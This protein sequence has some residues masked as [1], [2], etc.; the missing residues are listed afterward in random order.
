MAGQRTRRGVAGDRIPRAA[1]RKRAAH[2]LAFVARHAERVRHCISRRHARAG[3]DR[4][5]QPR[6]R[7]PLGGGRRQA[8]AGAGR[9]AGGGQGRGDPH[10]GGAGDRG[11]QAGHEHD[12]DRDGR[13][14]RPGGQR[15][16]RKPGPSG[17]QH[18]RADAVLVRDRRQAPSV[19]AG[20]D[21][22]RDARR[23]AGRAGR[24]GRARRNHR[25]ASREGAALRGG[26]AGHAAYGDGNS[27]ERRPA[28]CVRRDGARARAGGGG[29]AD[30]A[31]QLQPGRRRRSCCQAPPAGDLRDRHIYPGGRTDVL[32][33]EP[34]ADVPARGVFRGPDSQRR[35]TRRAAG[36]AAKQV[37]SDDQSQG[38]G[39][40]RPE[41]AEDPAA[42]RGPVD[43]VS[44]R[45][46]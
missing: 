15:I 31:H 28:F 10:R 46:S 42:A 36:R 25:I 24:I 29:A 18:H 44:V 2:R 11:S 30:P 12:P 26:E 7:V 8:R 32:R 43:R 37:R 21:T 35:K 40:A 45:G 16:D 39:R 13:G 4:G 38:R 20:A 27:K 33:A 14:R 1:C 17:R 9:R 6:H 34:Y 19:A 3:L 41:G 23:G 5:T 22:R